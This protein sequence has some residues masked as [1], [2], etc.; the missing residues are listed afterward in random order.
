MKC[1]KCGISFNT[2]R[3]LDTHLYI[4]RIRNINSRKRTACNYETVYIEK[5]KTTDQNVNKDS[6][7]NNV[8][9]TEQLLAETELDIVTETVY[10]P[11]IPP[12]EPIELREC[13]INN[14][15]SAEFIKSIDNAYEE[16]K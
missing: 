5:P 6:N 12:F 8:N 1:L 4:C 10:L 3:E 13:M 14:V 2:E 15:N 9:I 11:N 7:V 16:I